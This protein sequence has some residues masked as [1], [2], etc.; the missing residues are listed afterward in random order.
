VLLFRIGSAICR[1]YSLAVDPASCGCGIGRAILDAAEAMALRRGC[2]TVRLEVHARNARAIACYGKAGYR[3]FDRIPRYYGNGGTALRFEKRIGRAGD[4]RERNVPVI[5][6]RA[7]G[8]AGSLSPVG[9]G[10]G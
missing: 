9:R 1:L 8:S 2:H 3:E 6:S 4:S 7:A 10:L 5:R